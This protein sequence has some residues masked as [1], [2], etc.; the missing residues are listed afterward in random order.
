MVRIKLMYIRKDGV[1]FQ[2]RGKLVEDPTDCHW[3]DDLDDALAQVRDSVYLAL[4]PVT[5]VRIISEDF[6]HA[7]EDK[8]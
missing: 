6:G 2:G 3:Y 7:R 4:S 5:Q 8:P 1:W